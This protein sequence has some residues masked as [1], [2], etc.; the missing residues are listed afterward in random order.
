MEL[1]SRIS[2]NEREGHENNF[3]NDV[4]DDLT[5]EE[6]GNFKVGFSA[7][8]EKIFTI[9]PPFFSSVVPKTL[10]YELRSLNH[11]DL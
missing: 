11:R 7:P 2:S 3:E 6:V 4:S 10:K 9:E 1:S 8:K 5:T